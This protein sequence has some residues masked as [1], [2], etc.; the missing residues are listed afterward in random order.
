[1][2]WIKPKV[3]IKRLGITIDVQRINFDVKTVEVDLSE[4]NGDLWE[5]DFDEVEI[6]DGDG[7]Q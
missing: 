7:E 3:L 4:G 2:Q 1:M 6:V 5:F